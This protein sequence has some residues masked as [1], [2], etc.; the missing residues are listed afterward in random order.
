VVALLLLTVLVGVPAFLVLLLVHE[1]HPRFRTLSRIPV[2]P[3][4]PIVYRKQKVSTHPSPRAYGIHPASQG[5]TYVYF[6]D[7]FW[8]VEKVLR[9]GQIVVATRTNKHVYLRP[10]DPN[11]HK[12]GWYERL[13]YWK[14]FPHLSDED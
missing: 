2:E 12:A 1:F 11:L 10:N 13:R 14:R 6:I 7:K 4:D 5:D 3:G 9:D 8:T